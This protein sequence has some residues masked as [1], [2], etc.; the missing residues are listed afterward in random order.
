MTDTRQINKQEELISWLGDPAHDGEV[1]KTKLGTSDRVIARV[2]D[3]IYR[4]PA[5]ALRELISN[6]WDADATSVTILTDA[7]RFSRIYVRDNGIGM[8]HRSL[9]R[10]LKNIGG[11]AKRRK[12]GA[13]LG[14]TDADN[15]EC[16]P[17][18][19][20]IIGKIG[21][22]L[23]S[24]SQLSRR[25]Q[26]ITKRY[27]ESYR[28]IAEIR[29]RAY[30]EDGENAIEAEDDDDYVTGD[31]YIRREHSDDLQAHGTDIIL[32][33]VKPRVRDI[34][35]SS[36]RWEGVLERE[37]A[38]QQGDIDTWASMSVE[39]P[40]YHSGY[41][42][43]LIDP[44]EGPVLFAEQPNLPW[45]DDDPADMR[46]SKLVEK[47]EAESSVIDRPELAKTLDAYLELIWSLGLSAP[48]DYVDKHP[49]DLTGSDDV[50]L[51]WVTKERGRGLSIELSPN[52]T[53][54]EGVEAQAPGNPVL[55]AGR[56]PLG[57]F[58]VTIDGVLLK[59]PI[60]F[61]YRKAD[62]R[63]LEKAVM[64][65]GRFEPDLSRVPTSKRGGDLSLDGYL[66]WGG[67]I[68]PKENNGV[69]VRIREAS[70]ALF[71]PSF[72][73]YQVSEQ[74]RLRQITSELFVDRGLDAALN[75]DRESFN[76]AHPHL[77]LVSLWLHGAIRQLTNRL[78]AEAKEARD[79]RNDAN[80]TEE[81]TQL[82]RQV[83][84]IWERRKGSEPVPKVVIAETPMQALEARESG[85]FAILKAQ[86]PRANRS[87]DQV[88]RDS[89]M[90]ALVQVLAAY[91][92]LEG[93][94]YDEQQEL[95]AAIFAVF[96]G[97]A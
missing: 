8:D 21:I 97:E 83:S 64:F 60:K 86:I 40:S 55:R 65:V 76:F 53:V 31:V 90:E 67:R 81:R 18:G 96:L 69:L 77:Q 1:V 15:L 26:I 12:D 41:L 72:F 54:R 66:W 75:I 24:I 29:L 11:S 39:R 79:A 74:T 19:R 9:S 82:S 37:A 59:R 6:A 57:Q 38:Q 34:L 7:P 56:D 22:G 45:A 61:T 95:I 87:V 63:S 62:A 68:I 42:G 43:K 5:S 35:R 10:M 78:K 16:T 92:V 13:E 14:I 93:R 30:H 32:D 25:F 71:D 36:E 33:D 91:D 89:Q 84:G 44:K 23:F 46:M 2:T 47:V 50:Q 58:K 85:S 94:T 28:L 4:Q 80:S 17:S 3:G 49:F 48:V 52:Q 88:V 27:G 20:P 73:K 70:G 51:F